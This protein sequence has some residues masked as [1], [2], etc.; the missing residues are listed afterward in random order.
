MRTFTKKRGFFAAAATLLIVTVMLVTTWCSNDIG[1]GDGDKFI[2][3]EG[4]GAVKLGFNKE[5][6]RTILPDDADIDSFSSFEFIFSPTTGSDIT[7]TVSKANLFNPITL[8][9]ETYGLTVI[10]YIGSDAA[11]TNDPDITLSIVISA[12]KITNQVI[13]LKVYEPDGT[14]TGTFTYTLINNNNFAGTL[15]SNPANTAFMSF[16]PIGAGTIMSPI[17]IKSLFNDTPQLPITL[18]A[19]IYYLDYTLKVGLDTVAFRHI[20]HIYQGMNSSYSFS[21][22][23]NYF[24][25]IFQVKSGEIGYVAPTDY[26]PV[27]SAT[28]SDG[29]ATT[30]N[31]TDGSSISFP[32]GKN[33]TLTITNTTTGYTSYEWYIIDTNSRTTSDTFT[34]YATSSSDLFY[35]PIEYYLTVVGIKDNIPYLSVIKIT[36]TN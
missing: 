27:L 30:P 8:S 34:M 28:I 23:E 16:S 26:K 35:N 32:Q 29:G 9:P 24:K 25:A 1:D 11:A 33:L 21:I 4:K 13:S 31:L 36:V 19:G 14:E 12:G 22:N 3:P 7:V 18:I 20:V 6:N 15:N 2:L 17:N 5:I 10:A